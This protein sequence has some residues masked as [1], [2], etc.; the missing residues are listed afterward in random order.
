MISVM[1]NHLQDSLLEH[2][3]VEMREYLSDSR[4][5]VKRERATY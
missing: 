5:G 2:H 1:E 4:K 3:S